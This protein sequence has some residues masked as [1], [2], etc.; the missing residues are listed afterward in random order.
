MKKRK[1]RKETEEEGKNSTQ[2]QGILLKGQQVNQRELMA[3]PM[4][5]K[6]FTL[7][8]GISNKALPYY[9]GAA[10]YFIG[11]GIELATV[12]WKWSRAGRWTLFAVLAFACLAASIRPLVLEIGRQGPHRW[13]R[14]GDLISLHYTQSMYGVPVAERLR[15]EDNRLVLFE[16]DSTHAALEYLGIETKGPHN[17]KRVLQEFTIPADSVGNHMIVLGGDCIPLSSVEAD[18]GRIRVQL[19]LPPLFIFLI[20]S[21]WEYWR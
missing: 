14:E 8:N 10:K 15:V 2:D 11:K 20:H 5:N 19:A 17:V 21:L 3:M 6:N 1:V 9:K 16:V 18:E 13:V 4:G 12:N 7:E